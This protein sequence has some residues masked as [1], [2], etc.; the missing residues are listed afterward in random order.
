MQARSEMLLQA[1]HV[2]RKAR[3]HEPAVRLDPGQVNESPI[4]LP[5]SA[6]IRLWPGRTQEVA[7]DVEVPSVIGTPQGFGVAGP[8]LRAEHR[9]PMPAGVHH[10]VDG[11]VLAARH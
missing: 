6:R 10:D 3:K 1:R 7:V 5:K 2:A 4:F 8:V 11:A 9:A